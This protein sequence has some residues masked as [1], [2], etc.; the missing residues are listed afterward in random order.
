MRSHAIG[1]HEEMS[2]HHPVRLVR[3]ERHRVGVLIIR[4]R[5]PTSLSAACSMKFFQLA[6]DSAMGNWGEEQQL[7]SKPG[8]S[9]RKEL[10]SNA[11]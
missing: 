5:R 9:V 8:K 10:F 6:F 7:V 11:E 2:T 1:H 3:G 4:R